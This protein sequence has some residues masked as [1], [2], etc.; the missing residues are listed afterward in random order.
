MGISF[1]IG[2]SSFD[3]QVGELHHR[4]VQHHHRPKNSIAQ[5]MDIQE[6]TALLTLSS[7]NSKS[8]KWSS[9]GVSDTSDLLNSCFSKTGRAATAPSEIFVS[10]VFKASSV[11]SCL[12]SS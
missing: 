1:P 12:L 5:N 2:N 10:N 8:P 9:G 4:P 7:S 11:S 6:I 3:V